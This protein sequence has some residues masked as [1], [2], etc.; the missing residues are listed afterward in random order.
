MKKTKLKPLTIVLS[1]VISASLFGASVYAASG[2]MVNNVA[3]QVQQGSYLC[4]AA[5]SSMAGQYLGKSNATQKNIV[6]AAKGIYMDTAGTVYDA[7]TGLAAYGVSS[8]TMLTPLSYSTIVN[9]IDNYSNVLAFSS[10][11]GSSI[12]HA[13]LIKGYYYN[14]SNN[15]EN[16]YYIDPADGSSNVQNYSTFKANNTYTWKDSLAYIR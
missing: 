2:A 13:F 9:N 15:I 12:G 3:S 16:L 1:S 14:D 10:K 7:K 5:I 6:Q 11:A 4:W 8:S